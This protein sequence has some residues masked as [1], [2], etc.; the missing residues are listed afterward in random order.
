MLLIFYIFL[1]VYPSV[2]FI[3]NLMLYHWCWYCA[4]F[5]YLL[6]IF[7]I[8]HY[9]IYKDISCH[10]YQGFIC[11]TCISGFYWCISGFY[12]YN[13]YIRVLMMY[14]RVLL[15]FFRVLLMFRSSICISGFY[16]WLYIM[17]IRVVLIFIYHVCLIDNYI[18]YM[19]IMYT[20]VL[21]MIRSFTCIS[22][23][24]GFYWLDLL[25]VYQGSYLYQGF[26]DD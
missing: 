2:L 6:L 11:I 14:I 10:V 16:W 1:F 18:I 4:C 8:L 12:M 21:L 3:Q 24:S 23:I 15:I 20:S 19:Y 5:Y 9:R 7:Y 13:M 22:Y 26:I 17:Y 25:F